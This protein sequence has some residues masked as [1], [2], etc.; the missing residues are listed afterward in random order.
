M[1]SEQIMSEAI[2]RAV[3]E[4]TGIALQTVAEAQTERMH[5]GS[6]PK[7]DGP[8]MKQPMFNWNMQTNTVS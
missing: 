7:L 3:G 4:A 6:G 8:T 1:A 2:A 5:D